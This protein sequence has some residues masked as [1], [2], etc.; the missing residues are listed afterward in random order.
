MQRLFFIG[1][2]F[3]K[4]LANGPLANGFIKAIYQKVQIEDN[5]YRYS[6]DWERDRDCFEKLLVYFYKSILL[7][8]KKSNPNFEEFLDSLNLEFVCS[9]LDLHINH[10]YK[11]LTKHDKT[12][13]YKT[14]VPYLKGFTIYE[15]KSALRFIVHHVLDLLL[16][17]NLKPNKKA[18]NK[19][20]TFFKENDI[21]ISFNYDLLV[22][23]MLWEQK[24]WNPFDGYGI[25]FKKVANKYSTKSKIQLLKIHGSI[26]WR[27]QNELFNPDLELITEHP[28]MDKSLFEGMKISKSKYD[29]E[30]YPLYPLNPRVILPTFVK[31]PQYDWEMKLIKNARDACREAEEVYILG[32]SVP[33]AD[34]ITNLLF[35]DMNKNVEIF[36][37]LWDNNNAAL[38]LRSNIASKYELKEKRIIA[39]DSP[40]EK[41]IENDFKYKA[42]EKYKTGK[43]EDE[44]IRQNLIAAATRLKQKNHI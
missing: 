38:R 37:I 34:Y 32:Y 12:L 27:S 35:M 17:E 41:W 44:I 10:Y 3:T 5:K 6:G 13:I 19:M 21:I 30:K 7:E 11:K 2:G 28:F 18:I 22:E 4:A 24:L 31:T 25:P 15:L 40:I 42:W 23:N 33:V 43:K 8:A 1:A 16:E 20:S 9:F 14:P 39:E 36:I 26:N 29:K